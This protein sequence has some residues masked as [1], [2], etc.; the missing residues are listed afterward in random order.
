[1]LSS[2][3]KSWSARTTPRLGVV[4]S[5]LSL[6]LAAPNAQAQ[7]S[8][9]Y[10]TFY[11]Q[12]SH[13]WVFRNNYQSADRL[14]NAFDYGHA[15]LYE[16]LLTKPNAPASE[17]EEKVYNKLTQ[18]VLV[19]PPRV[20]LEEAAIEIKYA[21]LAPEAKVMFDWSH[22]LHRQIYD[23]LA[24][25]RLTEATKDREVQRLIAYYKT[26]RDVAF[27]SKPKSMKLM[28]E[29][30]YSLAFRTRYPKFNGLIW[31]YHWLQVGLYEPL[32]VGTT[33]EARQAGVRA[34]AARFWQMLSDPMRSLPYQMPMTAAVSPVFAARYPEA[35][36]I[37]DNLHSMHD[38]VSDIL[39]NPSVPRN[40]KRAEIML[41]A[42]RFRDDS[43]YVMSEAAWRTMSMEMGVQ[44]MGGAPVNFASALPE[45]TVTRGAVMQHDDATGKMIGMKTGSM[46]GSMAEM[47]HAAM[48]HVMPATDTALPS[49]SVAVLRVVEAF[50][51]ALVAGD[52]TA[53]L[54]LLAPDLVVMEAGGVETFAEFRKSHLPA[55]IAFARAVPSVRAAATVVVKGDAAWVSSTSTTEG[56]FRDRPVNSVGAELMVLSRVEKVWRISA[57]HWSSKAR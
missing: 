54:A 31:G 5:L 33:R 2:L 8:T 38:V 56:M 39:T 10:E 41:A 55:D 49:D 15:I 6:V 37:F 45:P 21:Q 43:S 24:D 35:A 19:R 47:D 26:R 13:N 28:Q 32:L 57:I 51:K 29:Q 30:P 34:T 4:A 20:P 44:N 25:E 18:Q 11:L 52:S 12:A 36:I 3:T 22:I 23:V 40:R 17:L 27:S 1:M 53:A 14:F 50:H 42:A 9:T 48:G 7:W 16:T 46:T